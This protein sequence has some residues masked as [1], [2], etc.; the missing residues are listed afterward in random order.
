LLRAESGKQVKVVVPKAGA[1]KKVDVAGQ[2]EKV[3]TR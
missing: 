1:K 2:R 3:A